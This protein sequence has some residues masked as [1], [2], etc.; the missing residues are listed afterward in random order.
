VFRNVFFCVPEAN[1]EDVRDAEYSGQIEIPPITKKGIEEA[2]CTAF[3]L[4]ALD[5][6]GSRIRPL[7]RE[8]LTRSIYSE[9][10][11]PKHTA[12]LLPSLLLRVAHSSDTET[13]ERQLHETKSI[14]ANAAT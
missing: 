6:A 10:L 11:Q 13:R 1:L 14:P 12:R 8:D 9:N 3:P 5:P 4:K 2:I 7:N